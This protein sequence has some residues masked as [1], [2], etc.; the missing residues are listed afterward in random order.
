[1]L[2]AGLASSLL[3]GVPLW[4][5]HGRRKAWSTRRHAVA[6]RVTHRSGDVVDAVLAAL[7]G[8]V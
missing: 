4:R 8:H 2:K 1:M 3:M 6:H 5:N 7:S